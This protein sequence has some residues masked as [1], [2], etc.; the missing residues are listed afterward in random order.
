MPPLLFA[1]STITFWVWF[2]SNILDLIVSHTCFGTFFCVISF[3]SST[4][5]FWILNVSCTYLDSPHFCSF[6]L[7]ILNISCTCFVL[8]FLHHFL[9]FFSNILDLNVSCTCFCFVFC[10]FFCDFLP[11]FWIL[12]VSC[13]CFG[14]FPL[15]FVSS[16]FGY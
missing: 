2:L 5:Y 11:I 8:Y 13:T 16:L 4:C 15:F 1:F 14:L 7:F 12:N 6:L 9:W 3:V 10:T